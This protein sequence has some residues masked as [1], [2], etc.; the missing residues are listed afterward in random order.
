MC[1]GESSLLNWLINH[2]PFEL[3]LPGYNY[4]GPG[5][6]L[7]KRLKRGDKGVNKLDEYCKEHDIAQHYIQSRL[8]FAKNGKEARLFP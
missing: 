2:L 1:I 5:T 8:N 6:K 3:H 4:C 7:I